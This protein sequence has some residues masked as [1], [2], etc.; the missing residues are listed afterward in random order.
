VYSLISSLL[1]TFL[2]SIPSRETMSNTRMTRRDAMRTLGLRDDICSEK[3][4]KLAYRKAAIKWHP[5]KNAG[6]QI[7][8]VICRCRK[9]A[10]QHGQGLPLTSDIGGAAA[11]LD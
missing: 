10:C 3:A 2:F 5:D 1:S 11:S 8:C 7:F 9:P 6:D 4:I